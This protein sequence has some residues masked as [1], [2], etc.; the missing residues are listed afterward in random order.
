MQRKPVTP[1]G[2]EAL[3]RDLGYQ[4]EV[5]R[6]SIIIDIE[7]ARAHGDISENS[8]FEDAK[9][10]QAHC[11]GRIRELEHLVATAEV[12]DVAKLPR[13]GKVRFGTTVSVANSATG[14]ERVYTIVG[15]SEADI[16]AGRISYLAPL[17]QA[18]M[19]RTE[20]DEVEVPT[21]GGRVRWEILAVRYGT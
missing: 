13:D 16:S 9:E 8:E 4:K 20:G 3:V 1:A 19:G 15:A 10:R 14:D 21:P 5:L 11:A 12:I 17:A 6:P 2:Y 18:L 7:E